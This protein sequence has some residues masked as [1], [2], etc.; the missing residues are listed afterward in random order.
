MPQ[1]PFKSVHSLTADDILRCPMWEYVLN[2]DVAADETLVRPLPGSRVPLNRYSLLVGAEC[3]LADSTQ[4]V[5][6][7][8]VN[9]ARGKVDIAPGALLTQAGYASI[10]ACSASAAA[11]EAR[12]WALEDWARVARLLD[13]PLTHI[14]PIRYALL[15]PVGRERHA[16]TGQ[17]E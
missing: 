17:I 8:I 14:V 6:F 11:R 9:T 13:R 3:H 15:I 2:E 4:T 10:P 16:R 12:S 1:H 7:M 5:G